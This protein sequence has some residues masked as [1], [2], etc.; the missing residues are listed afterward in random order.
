MRRHPGLVQAPE[1]AGDIAAAA[2]DA[3]GER[4]MQQAGLEHA[5][6]LVRI[7]GLQLRDP[8][9]GVRPAC[10]RLVVGDF[11]QFGAAPLEIAQHRVGETAPPALA[12][13]GNRVV[14]HGMRG[15]PGVGQLVQRH[16]Q[17]PAEFGIGQRTF[18]QRRQPGVEAPQLAQAAIHDVLQRAALARRL[19]LLQAL[20]QHLVQRRPGEHFPERAGGEFLQLTHGEKRPASSVDSWDSGH[21]IERRMIAGPRRQ[22]A[23]IRP[24][25]PSLIP[26]GSGRP[27]RKAAAL[28]R[29]LPAG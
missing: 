21:R 9:V 6:P 16:A 23:R 2:I 19:Q 10:R 8:P 20:R 1:I 15:R 3:Q 27:A 17:Q 25:A 14:H 12:G 29:L 7:F 5:L 22:P 11:F 28:I 18:Q 13:G 4:R 26:G 24:Q